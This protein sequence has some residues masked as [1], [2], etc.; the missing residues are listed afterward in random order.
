MR[1]SDALDKLGPASLLSGLLEWLVVVSGGC[2]DENIR[3]ARWRR[4]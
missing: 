4:A 3:V 2:E 1:V